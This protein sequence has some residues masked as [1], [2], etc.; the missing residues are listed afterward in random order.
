MVGRGTGL[1]DDATSDAMSCLDSTRRS[2][3][4]TSARR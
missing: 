1:C 2:V 4:E 3:E